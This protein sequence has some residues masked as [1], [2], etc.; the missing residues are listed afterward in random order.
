MTLKF[1]LLF[2]T[3]LGLN[4]FGGIELRRMAPQFRLDSSEKKVGLSCSEAIYKF[5]IKNVSDNTQSI[6]V[7]YSI[8]VAESRVNLEDYTF[9]VKVYPVGEMFFTYPSCN[10]GWNVKATPEGTIKHNGETFNYLFWEGEDQFNTTKLDRNQGVIIPQNELIS[11]LEGALTKF[12][13]TSTERANFITY[14]FP[15]MKDVTNL[16]IY[17]L[18]NGAC[19]EFTTLNISPEPSQTAHFYMLWAD[20]GNDFNKIGLLP[21]EIPT[22]KNDGFTVLE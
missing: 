15:N 20:S 17:F 16:Y 1:T 11:Y 2:P 6:D 18:F 5:K 12:G 22:F 9:E 4:S 3:L 10:D 21:Q 13:F 19:D 8:D 7:Q 14:W